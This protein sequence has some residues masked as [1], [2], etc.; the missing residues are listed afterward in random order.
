[1]RFRCAIGTLVGDLAETQVHSERTPYGCP[2]PTEPSSGADPD[3][4]SLPRTRS[5]AELRGRGLAGTIRTCGLHLRRVA[6]YPAELRR[7]GV[8]TRGRTLTFGF[9][10]R[11]GIHST[12]ETWRHMRVLT[13]RPP[14]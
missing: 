9:V 4:S 11:R 6:L 10:G 14:A 3:A 1:M 5:A 7:D 13:P 12:I 2:P 8:P